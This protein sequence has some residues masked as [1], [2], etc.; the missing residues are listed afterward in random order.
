MTRRPGGYPPPVAAGI[1]TPVVVVV[2]S[3]I[4]YDVS[5]SNTARIRRPKDLRHCPLSAL[6]PNC[7]LRTRE[8]CA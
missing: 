2:L 6:G 3:S 8:T 1:V 7:H 4:G 5:V